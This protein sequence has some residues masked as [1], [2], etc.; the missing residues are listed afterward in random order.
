[1]QTVHLHSVFLNKTLLITFSNFK[2]VTGQSDPYVKLIQTSANGK[3]TNTRTEAKKDAENPEWNAVFHYI[4]DPNVEHTLGEL[5]FCF[6]GSD[7]FIL[8]R[9]AIWY[10][11][12]EQQR[13]ARTEL[14]QAKSSTLIEHRAKRLAE[15]VW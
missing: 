9:I 15:R 8:Y 12:C 1:M 11:S 5:L 10:I 13:T 6:H 3:R 2:D 14:G 7:I 4:L